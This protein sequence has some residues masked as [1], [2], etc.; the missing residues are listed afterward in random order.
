MATVE[1][2]SMESI[3]AGFPFPTLTPIKNEPNFEAIEQLET[4]A[5]R[6]MVSVQCRIDAPHKNLC[7]LIEQL[8]NYLLRVGTPFPAIAYP[9]D[10]PTISARTTEPNKEKIK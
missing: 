8:S 3:K 10:A 6:N 9:G 7:G 4:K 2:P 1:A 5:I